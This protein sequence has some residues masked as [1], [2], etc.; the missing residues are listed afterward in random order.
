LATD[1]CETGGMSA[2]L[3]SDIFQ[4]L[5][6]VLWIGFLSV[7]AVLLRKPIREELLPRLTGFRAFGL[8]F[9]FVRESLEEAA[10]QRGLT[11]TSKDQSRVMRR[12][13]R[14]LDVLRGARV[15]WVDDDP[16]SVT[17]E[18][19]VLEEMGV[20]IDLVSS[21]DEAM[22]DLSRRTYDLVI[23]DIARGGDP[24]AGLLMLQSMRHQGLDHDVVFYIW[25]LDRGKRLPDGAF[26]ITNQPDQL[27]HYVLDV[28]ERERS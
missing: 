7:A 2:S 9:S 19:Q 6:T 11:L 3:S 26:G 13:S 5:P 1:A 12:A 21:T 18:R 28:L 17:R 22:K 16:K 25:S 8:E 24:E 14:V 4:I 15:L 27:I 23:S 20:L 10:A